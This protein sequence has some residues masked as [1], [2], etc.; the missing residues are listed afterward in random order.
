MPDLPVTP[1]ALDLSP[2]FLE[3]AACPQCHAKFALDYDRGE[4][5]CSDPDCGLA[6]PVRDGVPDLRIDAARNPHADQ[7]DPEADE[8]TVQ[9]A[10]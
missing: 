2:A 7:S 10:K 5:E 9:V 6:F 4:L 3:I 8:T 1:E